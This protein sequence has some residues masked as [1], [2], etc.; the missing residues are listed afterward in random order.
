MDG[1]KCFD[2]LGYCILTSDLND[3]VNEITKRNTSVSKFPQLY[4][5][6]K[7]K[8]EGYPNQVILPDIDYRKITPHNASIVLSAIRFRKGLETEVVEAFKNAS[9]RWFEN[10]TGYNKDNLPVKDDSP[11][12][13]TNII[14]GGKPV[15]VQLVR[16]ETPQYKEAINMLMTEMSDLEAGNPINSYR[17]RREQKGTYVNI[18]NLQDRLSLERLREDNLVNIKGR[19]EIVP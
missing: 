19:Y 17:V 3:T 15:F 12:R 13:R 8:T 11:V 7:K 1:L 6:K 16:E 5:P 18:K 2:G 14:A 10:Q 9:Q 4:W